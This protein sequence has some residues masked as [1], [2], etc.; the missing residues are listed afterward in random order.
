[1]NRQFF[2]KFYDPHN[3]CDNCFIGGIT[4]LNPGKKQ[5]FA[6]RQIEQVNWDN[7]LRQSFAPVKYIFLPNGSPEYVIGQFL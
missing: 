7:Q 4:N 2:L 6:F 1:M 5:L 3:S